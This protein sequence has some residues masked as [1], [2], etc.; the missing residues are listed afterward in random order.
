LIFDQA[1]EVIRIS[2]TDRPKKIDFFMQ[3]GEVL[4][5]RN[6]WALVAIREDYLAA[7]D[8]YLRPIPTRLANRYRLTFLGAD[9][10][11]QA[12]QR[13]AQESGVEFPDESANQLV[14]DLRAMLIQQPDGSISQ[15]LGPTV[16]P[17]QLQV[18]CRRLWSNLP[19]TEKTVTLEHVKALGNVNRALADYYALQVASVANMSG[20]PEREIREWFD[21]KLITAS[22]IRSQV[23]MSPD[24][25]EGLNN[26]AVW[27]LERA[28]LIRA[29]KR[30]GVTW[31]ELSHDRLVRPIRENNSE[32]FHEHLN[33]L[34]RQADIWNQQARPDTLLL[35]GPRFIEMQK[36]AEANRSIM[37]QAEK[38]FYLASQ[39]AQ[40]RAIRERQ[41]NILIRWLFG[42]SVIATFVSIG[43]YLKSHIDAQNAVARELAAASVGNLQSDPERSVLLALAGLQMTYKPSAEILQALHQSLPAVQV[44][45]ASGPPPEGHTNSVISVDYSP[46]GKFLASASKD[47]T[48]KIWDAGTFELLKTLVIIEDIKNYNNY[49]ALAAAYSPDGKSL[50]VTSADGRLSVWDTSS[51]DLKYQVAAGKGKI[52]TVAYSPDGAYIA[53]GGED[54][55]ARVWRAAAGAKIYELPSDNQSVVETLV[56]SVNSSL[57]FVGG[58]NAKVVYAWDMTSGELAYKLRASGA[59]KSIYGLA[60]SPDGKLLA[61]SGE[62]RLVRIWNLETKEVMEIPGHV[63]WVW[64]LAFTPDSKLLIS[65]SS[66]RTIRVW[67]TRYGRS[68]IVL[69]GPSGQVF[70]VSLHPDGHHLASASADNIV[71]TWDISPDGSHEVMA[72]D[73]GSD[74]HDVVVS[75]DG[76]LIASAG[77]NSTINIWNSSTGA[78]VKKLKSTP[79]SAEVLSWSRDGLYLAAGYGTGQALI[80]DMTT[81]EPVLTIPGEGVSVSGLSLHPDGSLLATG[82][83]IGAVYMYDAKTGE[84]VK[85]L[86]AN[87]E[88]NWLGSGKFSQSDLW[89]S[90]AV[91]SPDGKY[92]AVSYGTNQVVI[93]DW[94]AGK[95]WLTLDGH[96][97]IV[98]NVNYHSGGSL[99]VSGSDDANAILWDLNA[100]AENRIKTRFLGHSALIYDAA[101]SP[102]GKYVATG[103][104]DGL[105]KI[106]DAN[107]G[108]HLFDLYGNKNRVRAVTFSP[109]GRHVISG[110][111]D[112]TVRV[113]TLDSDELISLARARITRALTESEC[114]EYLNKSCANFK[115][116]DPLKPITDLISRFFDQ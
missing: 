25:S 3:L 12:I 100:P 113:Y 106:W 85:M 103:S 89:A 16:E 88:F 11:R 80:W 78:L 31:F 98:E 36:W 24:I 1:E 38:D 59:D 99:L 50:A 45:D 105:V 114:Q 67:D 22:G 30:G 62:D 54:G 102:D 104:A 9:A 66:D 69:T 63:D 82:N 26:K 53:T 47:G 70:G 83:D 42:A 32:W 73:H 56:F 68:Q 14:D 112:G 21:R 77:T 92:L 8:P 76:E 91:F 40:Q 65:A 37:T 64:G 111:T 4:R 51:W 72:L 74:I 107:R 43:F 60:V 115:I 13:P 75:P 61:S 10:A 35:V 86:D 49:G 48:V 2:M 44:I 95:P 84:L 79:S 28:Y 108:G 87:K 57:L 6:I 18:V 27:M 29:E 7:F 19:N 34:Q 41:A 90:G 5:D 96:T 20:V 33:V 71:R 97:D 39:K 55:S 81:Y 101:F 15:E 109:D 110:S 17:V 46:D 93:W 94:E 52:Y 23:L 116:L 58:D